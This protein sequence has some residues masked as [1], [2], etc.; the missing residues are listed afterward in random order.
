MSYPKSGKIEEEKKKAK[1]KRRKRP[2][3]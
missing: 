2:G 1:E 3:T